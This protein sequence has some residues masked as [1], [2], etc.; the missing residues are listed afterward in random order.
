MA[1]FNFIVYP[2]ANSLVIDATKLDT[3]TWEEAIAQAKMFIACATLC[4]RTHSTVQIRHQELAQ[5]SRLQVQAESISESGLGDDEIGSDDVVLRLIEGEANV[6]VKSPSTTTIRIVGRN[7]R[8]ASPSSGTDAISTGYLRQESSRTLMSK[9]TTIELDSRHG[10]PLGDASFNAFMDTVLEAPNVEHLALLFDRLDICDYKRYNA[11]RH[12]DSTAQR[13][14]DIDQLDL[15]ETLET[16][17]DGVRTTRDHLLGKLKTIKVE[18]V[19]TKCSKESS[20]WDGWL[21]G[22]NLKGKNRFATYLKE[23]API[24]DGWYQNNPKFRD[25]VEMED[26]NGI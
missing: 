14:Y 10:H 17:H 9:A 4:P 24:S 20:I 13:A 18:I 15:L 16:Y 3:D 11:R 21:A 23:N 5:S 25:D 1:S 26:G 12:L 2:N 22:G 7:A 8:S 6:L 19:E